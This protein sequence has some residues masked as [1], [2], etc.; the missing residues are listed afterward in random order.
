MRAMFGSLGKAAPRT[1]VTFVSNT[2]YGKGTKEKIG[3]DRMVLPV[4]NCRTVGKQGMIHNN[5]NH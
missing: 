5:K 1:C 2:A 3:Q 4:R